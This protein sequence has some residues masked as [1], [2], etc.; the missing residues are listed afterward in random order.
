MRH[1]HTPSHF[2]H[3]LFALQDA[4]GYVEALLEMAR[5]QVAEQCSIAT[6]SLY[7]KRTKTRQLDVENSPNRH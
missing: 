7:E 3:A 6:S 2:R 1:L 5:D 4:D